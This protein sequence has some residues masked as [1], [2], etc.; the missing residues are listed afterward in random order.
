MT[1]RHHEIIWLTVPEASDYLKVSKAT[2]Y[3][4][5]KDGRLPFFYI[6]GTRQRR[7]KRDDLNGLLEP[8][9]PSDLDTL[10]DEQA[11]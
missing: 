11:E 2:I 9:H 4:L 3:N 10:E 8:G 6:A 5:M 7:V 1:D